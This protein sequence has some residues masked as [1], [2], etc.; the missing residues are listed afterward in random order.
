MSDQTA[1]SAP[2]PQAPAAGLEGVVVAESEISYVDGE[3]GKLVYRGYAIEDLAEH[4][5][6]EETTALLL[7]GE[8]PSRSALEYPCDCPTER[9][10]PRAHKGAAASVDREE[11]VEPFLD[12]TD[13]AVG[14]GGADGGQFGLLLFE[15]LGTAHEGRLELHDP[16]ASDVKV[17]L[18]VWIDRHTVTSS[19]TVGMRTVYN[20]QRGTAAT[21]TG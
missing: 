7:N 18:G 4:S 12:S 14:P 6:F 9:L 21:T 19:P 13:E 20:R 2:P 11:P 10:Q 5:T 17:P 1:T 8:L 15:Q 3:A 16:P